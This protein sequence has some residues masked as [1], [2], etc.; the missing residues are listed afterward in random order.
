MKK[1]INQT[2]VFWLLIAAVSFITCDEDDVVLPQVVASFVHTVNQET[3]TVTFLNLSEN[4][5]SYSWDFGDGTTSTEI[6]PVK[7]FP[8]GVYTVVLTAENVAGASATFEDE[9]Y[10]NVPEPVSL[11]IT[12]DATNVDYQATTFNGAAFEVVD[13]P[14][15][16]GTNAVASKVGAITNSGAAFEGF[17]F[18]LGDPISLATLKSIK[19][20]FWSQTPVDVLLKLEE[21]TAAAIETTA[22]H[23][24]TGWQFIYFTFTGDAAFSRFTLFVDGPGTTAGTFYMDDVSQIATEDIP[25]QETELKLP[26]DFDCD[27]IDYATKIVG[28]VSFTVVDNPQQSG[29]NNE[30]TKVGQIT[31]VGAN[32]EN[33]FFNLDEPVNFST[34]KGVKMKLFS[35]QAVPVLLKFENGTEAPVENAQNH[36]GSGWEELTFTLNSSASYNDMVLFIDGPGT[37]AGTFYVD[38]IEQVQVDVPEPFDSGLLVNGDF[39]SGGAPWILGVD[40][41]ATAPVVTQGGNTLYQVN[42]TSPN[43]S[44]PFLVNLSQKLSIT[45]DETYVLTFDAWSDRNRTIIAGIG[46]S[47]GSFANTAETVSITATRQTYSLTLTANGF[48]DSTSRVLFDLNGEAG[49][50]NIDNVSLF[51]D[52]GS[53]GG[54]GGGGAGCSGIALPATAL[55]L[56]FEGC[57]SFTDSF[58]GAST[59]TV[60]LADN[61]SKTG[62]N[63]SNFSL[64]IVKGAGATRWAGVQNTFANNFDLTTTNTFKAMVYSSKANVVFRFEL[65][66]IPNDGSIGN[67][68][69]VFVTVPNANEW[70]EVEFTFINLPASPTTYNHLVIKPDNPDGTDGIN[71]DAEQTYYIDNLRLE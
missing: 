34:N 45:Q 43:P 49:L 10:V 3:G 68:A 40:D 60:E 44:E 18:D 71:T 46:L 57:E 42:I 25:C 22:S 48:G 55:P 26:I 64:K 51:V 67:P 52:G 59:I 47:G 24:G 15:L 39:E 37:T 9:V 12:F 31:N 7:T 2:K 54:G 69:P 23:T 6:N 28:N 13:N 33:A 4:S 70:T 11:P 50:V 21:G 62:I 36:A 16:S 19:V 1:W 8:T 30:A 63:T 56:D 41:N 66:V 35:N 29:I 20:N 32:W 5:D 61:P 53:G 58:T 65:L 17:F 14:D 38:D 27:G